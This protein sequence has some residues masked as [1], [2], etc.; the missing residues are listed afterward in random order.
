M[1]ANNS[2]LAADLE[3]LEPGAT[4]TVV[5]LAA[6]QEAPAAVGVG[7]RGGRGRRRRRRGGVPSWTRDPGRLLRSYY[8]GVWSNQRSGR[9]VRR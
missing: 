2:T 7:G 3:P 8:R 6:V 9:L 4:A 5:E 1:A